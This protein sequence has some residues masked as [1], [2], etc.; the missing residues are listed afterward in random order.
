M[1]VVSELKDEWQ[2]LADARAPWE[3]YWRNIA[4]Y[5][6]PQT[7]GF[8]RLL[9]T[10]KDVAINSVVS[11]PVASKRSKDIYDMTSL[12]G[13][14]RLT[15]GMLSLKTP[16]A[17]SWHDLHTDSVFGE[18]LTHEEKL[19]LERLRDY[20]FR[21]RA[22]PKSGFWSA[23]KSAIR[24]MCGFGDGWMYVEEMPGGG[25]RTPY[26]YEFMPLPELYPAVGTD[27]QPNRMFRVF[28]WSALQVATKW[29]EKAGSK[30]TAM[31]NDPTQRHNV[32]RVMHCV[33][34]REDKARGDAMGAKAGAFASH[35]CLPDDEVHIGEGGFYEYPF[36]RYAWSNTGTRPFSEGPVAYALGEIKSLQEMAKNELL[37][38]QTSLRPA[39]ATAGKNF[40]RLNLNPGVSNPGL[41][42]PDGRPLFAPMNS[43]VRPDFAQSV[44]E[45]RRNSVREM[46]YLNLWQII[47]QD[48]N[49][50]ATAALIKAQEKGEML[51]PVGISMNEGLSAMI[52]RE[53]SIL[54]RKRAFAEG[55]PLEMP[56]S[57]DQKGVSPIFT[58]PLDRLRRM[59]ELV[60]VQRLVEFGM[61]LEGL[62]PGSAA[63]RFDFDEML[64]TAQ[65][66]LGAPARTMRPA[67]EAQEARSQMDQMGQLQAAMETARSGGEAAQAAGRGAQELATGAST[68]GQSP[69]LQQ[70]LD[71]QMLAQAGQAGQTAMDRAA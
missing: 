58:S 6:L 27:G 3:T 4:A 65:D 24:S 18:E 9:S 29:P 66:V 13:I 7:E 20:Q 62:K 40:A 12:W 41:I 45:A 23:H 55:S 16:E 57:M 71:P 19:A 5:V 44:M 15:A 11:T 64:D 25:S 46:L 48:Q 10:N 38:I 51:G 56:A 53:V 2:A 37:A 49:D 52:D 35:Y 70:M 32:V 14:E 33:K 47:M 36:T 67:E 34:P 42:S 1:G 39:Y 28:R 50:T 68:A 21:V 43:G 22:N 54:D 17:Q 30:I 61:T 59:S 60:G 31:A 8:D 63:A 69:A 26:R